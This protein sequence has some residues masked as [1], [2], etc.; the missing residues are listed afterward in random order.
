[1]KLYMHPVS[2]TSR[3]VRLMIA[4]H[5]LPI[6]E[7]VVDLVAGEHL[8]PAYAA[9]N[10]S[11]LVPMLEERSGWRLTESGAILKYL[12]GRFELQRV[13]P[14]DLRARARVDERMDWF[15][16][17]FYRDF[18]YGLCYPQIFPHHRRPTDEL[19][20]G[21]VAWARERVVGWLQVLDRHLIGPEQDYLC[22]AQL[23]IA[24]YFG[25]SLLTLGD[26]L[27]IDLGPYPHVRR[28]L[29]CIEAL[30][31]WKPVNEALHGLR[32]AMREQDFVRP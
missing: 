30:P 5:H 1:M 14:T 12:A 4:E 15:A 20:R 9:L 24:D 3:P 29:S 16:T 31:S 18:G 13:Y 8:Q 6:E 11:K 27:R 32:D 23:T 22:G 25:S 21:T 26:V 2:M 19:Q 7:Q 28:W 17:N 10:P